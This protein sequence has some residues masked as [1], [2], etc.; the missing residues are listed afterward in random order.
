MI[1][2]RRS[3]L[4]SKNEM[5]HLS[6]KNA[7]VKFFRPKK[8]TCFSNVNH[9]CRDF[10]RLHVLA[11]THWSAATIRKL[12]NCAMNTFI[13]FFYEKMALNPISVWWRF[14]IKFLN[15]QQP[16]QKEVTAFTHLIFQWKLHEKFKNSVN[17]FTFGFIE[18]AF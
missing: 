2:N 1:F 5:N 9:F 17:P 18:I 3:C 7:P 8:S 6:L 15:L 13:A 12:R 10:C 11:A 4:D 14:L 16:T